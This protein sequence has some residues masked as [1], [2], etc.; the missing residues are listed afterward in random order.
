VAPTTST[1]SSTSI[2]AHPS[3]FFNVRLKISA[4]ALK[5]PDV[6]SIKDTEREATIRAF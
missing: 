6:N 4:L 3:I 5:M 2:K 1:L